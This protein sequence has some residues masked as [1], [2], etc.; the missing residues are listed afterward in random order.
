V[1]RFGSEGARYVLLKLGPWIEDSNV[2]WEK[3]TEVYNADLANGIGNLVQRVATLA[4]KA[5]V[6]VSETPHSFSPEVGKALENF[7]LHKAL[8]AIQSQIAEADVYVNKEEPWKKKGKELAEILKTAIKKIQQIA[9]DIK[10]FLPE[11]GKKVL[12]QYTATSIKV[13]SILFT[14]IQ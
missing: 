2:S 12:E 6:G 10:P 8:Q 13:G 11:A 14:R 4:E 7:E 9:V 1:D 5:G 3:F